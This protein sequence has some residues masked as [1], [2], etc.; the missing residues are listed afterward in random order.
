MFMYIRIENTKAALQCRVKPVLQIP[1]ADRAVSD[2]TKVRSPAFSF[3]EK[4]KEGRG[5][6]C[7][8]P[9]AYN[10]AGLTHKG[11]DGGVASR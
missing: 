7:P 8:A 2:S 11:K 10:T 5:P 1:H 6:A 9:N 4:P 3:G